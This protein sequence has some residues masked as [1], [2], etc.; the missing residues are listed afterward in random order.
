[1]DWAQDTAAQPSGLHNSGSTAA[2]WTQ[3][4]ARSAAVP[5]GTPQAIFST[6]RWDPSADPTMQWDFAAQAGLPLEVRLYLSNGCDCTNDPGERRFDVRIDGNLVL[7]DYDI[8]ADTGNETGTMRAFDIVSDGNVDLDFGHVTENPLVNGIEIVRTDIQP[9]P[10]NDDGVTEVS[11]TEAGATS[12]STVDR[13]AI[14]WS[15]AR[16]AFMV[17]GWLYTGWDD[18]TFVR[19]LSQ[20]NG[21]GPVRSVNLNGLT[22]FAGELPGVRAMWF[23]R[24]SGRLY[25]TMGQD[26]LYYRY[27][28]PESNIVGAVRFTAGDGGAE[29][30]WGS[31]LGGFLANGRLYFS[32]N[33][34]TLSSAQW[35]GGPVAGSRQPV[36]G[37]ATDGIDWRAR[38]LFLQTD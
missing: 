31:V 38:A 7:D 14:D 13:G 21:F 2:E 4:I 34:G 24:E 1:M 19:R 12:S 20:G 5:A 33:D 15:R 32:S 16:G 18:G 36:S 35:N 10:V 8:V 11:L 26:T 28:T 29:I 22:A 37:P 17:D 9:E 6:E 3:P 25:Y 30:D 23:D 27:F